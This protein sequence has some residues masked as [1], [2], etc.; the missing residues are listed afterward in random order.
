[1][2]KIRLGMVDYLN[3]VPVYQPLEEGVIPLAAQIV[4]GPPTRLNGMFIKGELDITPISSIEYA[5]HHREALILPDLAITAD[6]EVMSISL[7]GKVPP[8]ELDGRKVAL[9]SSSA[10]SVVLLKILLEH[11]YQVQPDY[12]TMPPDL[13]TMLENADAALLIGDDAILA[14]YRCAREHSPLHVTDLGAAWKE[15]TGEKMVY[16]LWVI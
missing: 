6:G 1:M 11:Y 9:T 12:M 15:F 14:N 7:I 8:T 3:C 2:D 16:A 4:K 10:T 5:R 13:D